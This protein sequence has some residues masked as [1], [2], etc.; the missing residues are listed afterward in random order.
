MSFPMLQFPMLSQYLAWA[1]SAGCKV[2]TGLSIKLGGRVRS[3][4][5][6]ES[7]DGTKHVIIANS[8][9]ERLVTSMLRYLD[10]RLGVQCPWLTFDFDPADALVEQDKSPPIV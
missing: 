7:S 9:R 6:I 8:Q 10:R 4:T 5:R 1:R 2:N 3:V